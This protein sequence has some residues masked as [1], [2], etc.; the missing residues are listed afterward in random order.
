ENQRV[1]DEEGNDTGKVKKVKVGGGHSPYARIWGR[2]TSTEWDPPPG[3][4]LARL[5]SVQEYCTIRLNSKGHLFLNEVFDE[6]GLDRT[7]AGAVVG[8]LSEKY[9]GDDGFGAFGVPLAGDA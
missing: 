2:D 8:W 4:N 1:L 6:L 3:Y 7:P 9:G 5:R